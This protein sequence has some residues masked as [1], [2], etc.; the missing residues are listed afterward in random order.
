MRATGHA[1]RPFIRR[2]T[3]GPSSRMAHSRSV[4]FARFRWKAASW[5]G[6]FARVSSPKGIGC[7]SAM[8]LPRGAVEHGFLSFANLPILDG[9]FLTTSGAECSARLPAEELELC[10]HRPGCNPC[11]QVVPRRRRLPARLLEFLRPSA[12]TQWHRGPRE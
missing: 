10:E 6:R 3:I 11:S 4:C 8:S 5:V 9:R 1:S 7:L 2:G 12:L